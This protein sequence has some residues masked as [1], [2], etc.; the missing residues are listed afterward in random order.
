MR[1]LRRDHWEEWGSESKQQVDQVTEEAKCKGTR[2]GGIGQ[3]KGPWR[4]S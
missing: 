2:R 3:G 4:Q 1:A